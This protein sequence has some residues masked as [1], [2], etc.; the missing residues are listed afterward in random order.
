LRPLSCPEAAHPAFTTPPY[1]A[2]S[3]RRSQEGTRPGCWSRRDRTMP[4]GNET[5]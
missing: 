3:A 2:G 5:T 4:L 1:R